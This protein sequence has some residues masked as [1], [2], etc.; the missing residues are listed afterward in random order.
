MNIT[1]AI[2]A[3]YLKATGKTTTVPAAKKSQIIGLLNFYQR[4][5]SKEKDV[6]WASLY[7]PS[8]SIGTVTAT[9]RFDLDTSTVRKLSD[10]EGDTVTILHTDGVG[11]TEY[12]IL[13]ANKLKG[14]YFGPQKTSYTGHYCAR[15]GS[16][17]VFNHKFTTDD[18]E[19]GGDIQ[20]PCYT[21]AVDIVSTAL[22]DDVQV[23]DADWLVTRAA[24]EYVRNDITRRQR[25]PEL[26]TEANEMMDRMK[27][28]QEGQITEINMPWTPPSG[29]GNDSAWS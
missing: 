6:D 19:F 11:Y 8:F 23:D 7:D 26:L 12:D 5:W 24:A 28:D 3:T 18:A 13:P 20:V 29:I 21:Y 2:A 9:D 10:L 25:Y 1:D 17:L 15:I 14:K 16:E 27:D 4:N 22:D